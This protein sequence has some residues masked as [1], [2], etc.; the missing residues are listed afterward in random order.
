MPTTAKEDSGGLTPLEIQ[1][2]LHKIVFPPKCSNGKVM[3]NGTS[4]AAIMHGLA[5][6]LNRESHTSWAGYETILIEN[7]L[8]PASRDTFINSIK[9]LRDVYGILTWNHED[10]DTN[11]YWFR[12]PAIKQ[13]I[14]DQGIWASAGKQGRLLFKKRLVERMQELFGAVSFRT[15]PDRSEAPSNGV[16]PNVS[17]VVPNVCGVVQNDTNNKNIK[18]QQINP[19]PDGALPGEPLSA[20]APSTPTPTQKATATPTAEARPSPRGACPLPSKGKG[21]PKTPKAMAQAPEAAV[22]LAKRFY[23]GIDMQ[24]TLK[25]VGMLAHLFKKYEESEIFAVAE[26]VLHDNFW[27]PKT[28]PSLFVKRFADFLMTYRKKKHVPVKANVA[29]PKSESVKFN[30]AFDMG[31]AK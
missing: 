30:P 18:E 11:T 15:T 27:A 3:T 21:K 10:H 8:S 9:F 16:V 25:D 13:L 28:T 19:A 1:K 29:A 14:L 23:D 6:H 2:L 4:V 12:V 24:P 26:D 22:H 17:G 20:Q 31:G 5:F 7:G